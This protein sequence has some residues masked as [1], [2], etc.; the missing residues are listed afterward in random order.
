MFTGAKLI[1]SIPAISLPIHN[2]TVRSSHSLICSQISDTGGSCD[3]SMELGVLCRSTE[4]IEAL[5]RPLDLLV[6]LDSL[7]IHACLSLSSV[8]YQPR[9][10]A[11][12]LLL[13][14]TS[15]YPQ[16]AQKVVPLCPSLQGIMRLWQTT[17]QAK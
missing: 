6:F 9:I 4:E 16:P 11:Q 5:V 15:Q 8:I 14:L 3:Y 7:Y 17:S 2:R 12:V 13:Q 1:S 10:M